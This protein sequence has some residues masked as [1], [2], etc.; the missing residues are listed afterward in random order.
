MC[1][2]ATERALG[3]DRPAPAAD[4]DRPG[5]AVVG[6]GV[7]VAPGGLPEQRAQHVG[8][9]GRHLPHGG[10]APVVEAGGGLGAH[11]PQS[12]DG[13]GVQEVQLA[14]GRHLQQPVGLGHAAGHLGQELGPGHPDADG[15]PDLV[16]DPGPQAGRDV[17]RGPRHPA[18]AADV[19]EGLVDRQPLH[20]RR[21]VVEDGEHGPAGVG[22]GLPPGADDHGVGA[23]APGQAA[24]HGRSARRGPWPRS[25]TPAPPRRRRSP[26]GRAA[27]GRRAARPRRRRR[28]GRRGGGMP[29]RPRTHVRPRDGELQP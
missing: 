28:R 3:P 17:H 12:L 25:C 11:A 14:V 22:V 10:D 26:A 24:A 15:Q 4:L 6:Q 29:G 21:G 16:E 1:G 23:Q 5:V 9:Q 27:T 8:A 20:Q 7:E 13:E 19:E 18:Q 2:T